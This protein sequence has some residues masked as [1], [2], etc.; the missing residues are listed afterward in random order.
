MKL[1][2]LAITALGFI[3]G[4][5]ASAAEPFINL[6]PA[7]KEMAVGEGVFT[8]PEGMT[9]AATGHEAEV[10]KFL[11]AFNKA[12]GLNAVATG[13]TEAATV[14]INDCDCGEDYYSLNV[15]TGGITID[16]GSDRALFYAFQTLKKLLPANVMAEV[17]EDKE[18][19]LPLLSITD[20]PRMAYR[21]F[22]LDCSRHFFPLEEL[23]R[24]IDVMAYYKMNKFHWHLTDDQGWRIEMP[25]YPRLTTVGATAPNV[26]I[27]D[28]F[29]KTEYWLNKPYGP[30]F[31]TQDEMRELVAYAAER[32]IDIIP[33]VEMPGHFSAVMA[34][35]PEFSLNPDG[36]HSVAVTGGIYGDVMNIA[37]PAA[38]KFAEDVIDVLV[39]IFPSEI[40]HIGGDECPSGGWVTVN[41]NG[42]VTGGNKEC[43]AMY[44]REGCTDPRQLQSIFTK[45]MADYCAAKGRTIGVW[46]ESITA[47]GT[48]EKLMKQTGATVWC[49]TG[50][51]NAVDKA[52]SLGL[53][54]IYT[55]IS[56]TS[57][58]K[59]SFYIN[60][61]QS[62]DDPPANGYKV[63]DVK[64]VYAT[65][66]FTTGALSRH[67]ELCYGVQGTFWCERVAYGEYLE[68]LALP[69]LIAIAEIGWTPQK[70]RNW[71]SFQKRMSADRELLDY[72][73]YRYSP[74][75][76]LDDGSVPGPSGDLTLKPFESGKTYVFTNA[77]TTFEGNMLADN[78]S[79]LLCHS[80]SPWDNTIWTVSEA[81]PDADNTHHALKLLNL[82]TGKAISA[83]G[84]AAGRT[85]KPVTLGESATEIKAYR[86]NPDVEAFMLSCGGDILWTMP[87]NDN[88]NGTV[89]A[90]E[91]KAGSGVS[92][93][94]GAVWTAQQVEA[95]RFVA[96]NTDGDTLFA[97]VRGIP[98]GTTGLDALAPAVRDHEL[99]ATTVTDDGTVNCTYKKVSETVT[100]IGRLANGAYVGISEETLPAGSEITP[101]VPHIDGFTLEQAGQLE[102]DADGNL[103]VNSVYSTTAHVGAARPLG[104]LSAVEPGK[105]YLIRDAH[106]DRNAYRCATAAST[107]SGA[108]SAEGVSPLFTWTLEAKGSGF[109]VK[110]L[111]TGEYVQQL[112][113][114]QTA[115]TGRSG[116]AFSFAYDTDHWNVRG[117][118]GMYWDGLDNLDL[119]GWDGGTG[120]PIEIYEFLA[121][122]YFRVNVS[123]V[124]AHGTLLGTETRFARA[125]EPY[126]LGLP[127]RKGYTITSVEGAEKLKDLTADTDVTIVYTSD[128]E[129][130]ISEISSGATQPDAVY[131]LQGRR[132]ARP[133]RGLY[134]VNG[135]KLLLP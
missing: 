8:L 88:G 25:D 132:V 19:S 43:I 61:S 63:D 102:T 134:I 69:R 53:K 67:P 50:A 73:G 81:T 91:T 5:T 115:K 17:Y 22:M 28:M 127:Y 70:K 94:Q 62:P 65:I 32:Y 131:D 21:G 33:E 83:T 55:P 27:V 54:A 135:R 87:G 74:Y 39:D 126:I 90:G 60:R 23:K 24:M 78:N 2:H 38:I 84:D 99:T 68:Y 124:D 108:K 123:H 107:V 92:P 15:T 57:D 51:D 85:G 75:H 16:A 7:P 30:Y 122:P 3:A 111:G 45:H 71:T 119:V 46:N 98:A 59:G 31:Y 133:T 6:T 29:T 117:G 1:K 14:R 96:L 109:M 110:N 76:M 35:Y 118:N 116:Y 128:V 37:N 93:F 101:D 47:G 49:W 13:D 129:L 112:Q 34:A 97:G 120:H 18:Y 77:A 125:G 82:G 95:R 66:P 41:A 89:R 10:G 44:E 114:S 79:G 26:E 58:T 100:Y 103:V 121:E 72:N 4:L 104:R 64:S 11:T 80:S 12:T 42:K 20:Q 48:D 113:R 52:A 36:G 105:A 130:S 86:Y 106:V 56:K 9:V 40:I